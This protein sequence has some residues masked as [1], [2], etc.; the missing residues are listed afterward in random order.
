MLFLNLLFPPSL[1]LSFS[2][3]VEITDVCI[4]VETCVYSFLPVSFLCV[5]SVTHS[6]LTLCDPLDCVTHQAPLSMEFSRRDAGVGSNFL[7]QG[8]FP[9]QGS[10][11]HLL[12]LLHW[13]AG[14]LPLVPTGKRLYICL[15]VCMHIC[16]YIYIYIYRR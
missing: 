9:T 14:S 16:V 4:N 3:K 11:P 5:C 12:H 7:L 1:L 2:V 10:N 15:Y 8:I 13:Q 6:C